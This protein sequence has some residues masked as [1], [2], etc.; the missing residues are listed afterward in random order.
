MSGGFEIQYS[1]DGVSCD[2]ANYDRSCLSEHTLFGAL[3]CRSSLDAIGK[4]MNL[5]LLTYNYVMNLDPK[6][7]ISGPEVYSCPDG[8]SDLFEWSKD[9]FPGHTHKGRVVGIKK[10]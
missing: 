1:V 9:P 3:F 10:V 8:N 4:K 6:E 5:E 2:K 7:I